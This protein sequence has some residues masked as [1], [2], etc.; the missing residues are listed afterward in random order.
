MFPVMTARLAEGHC[1]HHALISSF[2]GRRCVNSFHLT[3]GF[4][5]VAD[6]GMTDQPSPLMYPHAASRIEEDTRQAWREIASF[7]SL[8]RL[9]SASRNTAL[10]SV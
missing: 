8:L 5:L 7:S 1:R 10:F 4:L 6:M 2:V 3:S 9:S